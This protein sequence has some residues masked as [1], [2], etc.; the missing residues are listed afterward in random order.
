MS[1]DI[2]R[3]QDVPIIPLY[4]SAQILWMNLVARVFRVMSVVTLD[5]CTDEHALLPENITYLS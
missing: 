1:E 4:R 2:P 3:C 5:D